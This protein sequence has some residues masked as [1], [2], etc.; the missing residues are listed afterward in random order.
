M[1]T[2]YRTLAML[3]SVAVLS[4]ALMAQDASASRND[5]P[6]QQKVTSL[7]QSKQEF[8]KV[9]SS[10]EDGIVTLTGTVDVYQKKLDVDKKVRKTKDVKGVRNL[11]EVA[12][13]N[14]PDQQLQ[15]QLNKK[16]VYE[17]VGYRDNTFSYYTLGVKDGVVTVGGETYNDVARDAALSEVQHMTGVKD[18]INNI[19][20]LPASIND[21]HIRMRTAR[22]I[23][24][25]PVLSRYAMDPARPIKIIVENGHVSLYGTVEN[26]MDKQ[27]AGMRAN[28]VFGAFS[29]QNNLIVD[30]ERNA[31][32]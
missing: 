16:L 8:Q 3:M 11:V 24:R 19:K 7:L 30:N 22:A 13:V 15:A 20:V 12:G 5:V 26:T 1:K 18:V 27:V 2:A 29:V 14:V 31:R 32:M 28:G 6:I 9:N 4:G 21:D 25:D 10:V 17:R 23:Y